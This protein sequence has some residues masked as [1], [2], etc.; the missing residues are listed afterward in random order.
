MTRHV[1][2]GWLILI[3]HM[4]VQLD[5]VRFNRF[6]QKRQKMKII[7]F[8][9]LFLDKCERKYVEHRC[10]R[11]CERTLTFWNALNHWIRKFNHRKKKEMQLSD[12][13]INLGQC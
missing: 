3:S 7:L 5:F 8:V 11:K 4:H 9:Y 1:K 10:Y 6:T 13:K 2:W 12:R